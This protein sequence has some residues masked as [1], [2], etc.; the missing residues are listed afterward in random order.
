MSFRTKL[1]FSNNRQVKQSP[2]SFTI[3]SGGTIF[4]VAYSALTTGPDLTTTAIT[5]TQLSLVSSFSG[6][7][8]TTV[9]T[10]ANPSMSIAQ[11]T[12]SAITPTN[13]ATTQN[14]DG[15][16]VG[17]TSATTVDGYNYYVNY[18]GVSYDVFVTS[19]D[20]LGAG[21]YS[22]TIFTNALQFIS[23]NGLDYSGRTIWV[24]TVGI[25][26]TEDLIITK[27]P[28][29]GYVWTCADSEGK[30][31]WS[32]TGAGSGYWSATT[33][34][35]NTGISIINRESVA[36]GEYS[37]TEGY[38]NNTIGGY[39]HA[40]GYLSTASGLTSFVHG[41][42]SIAGGDGSIVLGNNITGT[43]NNFTYVESLNIKT[44]GAGPGATDIGV[45][46]NGNVVNQASDIRLKENVMVITN[47]LDKVL[48][49][50]GVTYNW[51]DRNAGGD[52]VRYGFIAQ[53]VN[54]IV[55]ELTFTS[56]SDNYLGVQYKDI[57]ALLVEA[58]KEMYSGGSNVTNTYLQTQSIIAEDNNIDL[59][60][61]GT[62][63]TAI[64]GGISVLHG[65]NNDTPAT[66][67][68]DNDGN[69]TTNN[70]FKP[71]SLSIPAY[72]PTSSNDTY[73]NVGNITMD[74]NHIYI[75]TTNGW[76]RSSLE[77]F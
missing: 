56:G 19:M 44:I 8:G 67:V 4:G 60:Y 26:R 12:L 35:I 70:D 76:K 77:S 40:G 15:Y 16:F 49:L 54:D 74:D 52:G 18:S 43:S 14:V 50:R 9:F 72:T 41:Q 20:D 39:S 47:A 10:W 42:N 75:K 2:E 48:N 53:E 73:G 11:S 29:V 64:G 59:N 46:A 51:K 36:L 71:N 5:Q 30:G 69:W 21:A 57:T 31:Q 58:V 27:S 45:D 1:D 23:A 28:Q 62:K 24:D 3:L 22:G 13:S 66:L 7:S 63:E 33:G 32:V 61:G 68:I 65:I 37:L 34:S 25:T 55:P 17:V 6:N 38:Q